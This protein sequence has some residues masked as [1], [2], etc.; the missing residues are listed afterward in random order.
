L[1]ETWWVATGAGSPSYLRKEAT[2]YYTIHNA[3]KQLDFKV[4]ATINDTWRKTYSSA[5]NDYSD[6]NV[7]ALA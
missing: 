7:L 5:V 4:P 2:G 3:V 1:G 6:F